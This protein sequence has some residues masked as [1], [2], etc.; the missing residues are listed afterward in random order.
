MLRNIILLL[1]NLLAK[2]SRSKY[3]CEWLSLIKEFSS[4]SSPKNISRAFFKSKFIFA[5]R[6]SSESFEL[7]IFAATAPPKHR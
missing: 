7:A 5:F 1:V 3:K 6:V 2:V 4:L